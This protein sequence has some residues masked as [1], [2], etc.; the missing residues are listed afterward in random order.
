[1]RFHSALRRAIVIEMYAGRYLMTMDAKQEMAV[2]TFNN[3]YNCA[4]AV[5]SA[6]CEDYGLNRE[7]ALKLAGGLGGGVRSG[8]ICGAVSGAA[9]VIGLKYG[10]YAPG[11]AASKANCNAK[12]LEFTKEF[13]KQNG[14]LNCRELLGCDI[15]TSE[16]F[17]HAQS[18]SLCKTKCPGLVESAAALLE[19]LGY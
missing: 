8:N 5:V 13:K 11:D 19:E 4:Q 17:E 1:M 16:G 3:G 6:F 2:D 12:T 9:L 7:T 14:A 15:S 18:Q 10:Q